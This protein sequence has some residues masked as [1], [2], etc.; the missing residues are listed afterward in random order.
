MVRVARGMCLGSFKFYIKLFFFVQYRK[1]FVWNDHHDKIVNALWDVLTGKTLRL[2]INVAPRYSKTEI[3]VKAFISFVLG[4]NPA[5][6]FIHLSYGDDIALDNSE[7]IKDLIE[8]YEYQAM[9]PGITIKRDSKGKK[10]WY[11]NHGGGLLARSAAGQVT[12]FGAGEVDEEF[13]LMDFADT[14]NSQDVSSFE[15]DLEKILRFA[16]A[17]VIDDPI[18]PEDADQEILRNR[19]NSRFDSTIRNRVNSRRT[20]II[21]IQQRLHPEDLTG[22]L[23]RDDEPDDWKVISLPC[24]TEC[25]EGEGQ[26]V[27]LADGTLKW[28][29]ALWPHKHTVDELLAMQSG[30]ELVFGRQYQQDPAPKAGLLFP[31]SELEMFDFE[32]M[33]KALKDPDYTLFA[34]DP[35]DEGGDDFAGGIG[36]LIGDKI[37]ITD[38][39]YNTDGTDHNEAAVEEIIMGSGHRVSTALVEG[40]F[41]WKE[42]ATRIR[43]RITSK[44]KYGEKTYKNEFRIVRP[45]S[46]K[47]SRILN[48]A[49]FIKNHMR[50]RKDWAKYPQYAKFMRVL[51][52]YLR[53]QEPGKKNKHD[54]APDLLEMMAAFFEKNF[55]HL[56]QLIKK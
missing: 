14:I 8:S 39:L 55:P 27:V 26:M 37:Y 20:P 31:L 12:G 11:T 44:S 17:I 32:E 4:F 13:E 56:W 25:K 45:R 9:F 1:K 10:K 47:E 30:N 49:S 51:I 54:D 28:Y 15:S 52:S 16:G 41:G 21:L 23:L 5:A 35:A 24:L 38:I 50:F 36:K 48:R 53:I 18:K 6:K 7:A 19:V 22:Y 3:V 46:N 33:A 42:T 29:K 34:A 2:I 43:D 40:V